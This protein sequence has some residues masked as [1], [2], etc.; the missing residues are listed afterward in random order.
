MKKAATSPSA[1]ALEIRGAAPLWAQNWNGVAD[2]VEVTARSAAGDSDVDIQ[3]IDQSWGA[4]AGVI[5]HSL[6][7]PS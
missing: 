6:V 5:S 2:S 1:S 7:P 4:V 3:R